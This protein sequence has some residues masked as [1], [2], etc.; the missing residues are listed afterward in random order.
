VIAV[1]SGPSR[2]SKDTALVDQAEANLACDR[3]QAANTKQQ[4]RQ[5]AE[6]NA[7]RVISKDRNDSYQTASLVADE[8]ALNSARASVVS[9]FGHRNCEA[10]SV[11]LLYPVPDRWAR[12][13]S[14][15]LLAGNLV[16]AND[17]TALVHINQLHPVYVTFNAREQFLPEIRRYNAEHAMLVSATG[18]GDDSNRAVTKAGQLSFIDNIV[19]RGHAQSLRV[20]TMDIV[21]HPRAHDL[22]I[23]PRCS[24]RIPSDQSS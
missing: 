18:V 20:V 3:A 5:Y 10:Q 13:G 7:D 24:Q 17:T 16:K 2:G 9:E 8:A 23:N 12:V 4:A 1:G 21:R 15:L 22:Q 19:D 14:L 6:L 11:A